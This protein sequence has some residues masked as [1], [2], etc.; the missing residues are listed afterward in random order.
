MFNRQAHKQVRQKILHLSSTPW[1]LWPF[2]P[3]DIIKSLANFLS[4]I[5]FL[6]FLLILN[7]YGQLPQNI[8]IFSFF[9][10]KNIQACIICFHYFQ[11]LRKMSHAVTITRTTTTTTSTS[12]LILNTGYLKTLPG[13]L[14]LAQLVR[15]R[16][17]IFC[18]S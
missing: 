15:L 14:K 9:L 10:K 12:A 4:L 3:G 7:F 5:L 2:F 6:E 17:W 13:V 18:S 16:S 11:I 1:E 8:Y